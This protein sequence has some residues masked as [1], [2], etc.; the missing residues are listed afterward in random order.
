[1]VHKLLL[2]R[3]GFPLSDGNTK[4][5]DL[6]SFEKYK[7]CN[8]NGE[9]DVHYFHSTL[10]C[11][12]K[13][14]RWK[15]IFTSRRISFKVSPSKIWS[16]TPKSNGPDP[17]LDSKSPQG[18]EY[19]YRIKPY[20]FCSG[21]L[22]AVLEARKEKSQNQ[23]KHKHNKLLWTFMLYKL[24]HDYEFSWK[25]NNKLETFCSKILFGIKINLHIR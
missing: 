4:Y 9:L 23:F 19:T 1:M 16:H 13:R 20:L 8:T 12:E 14:R 24:A 22:I 5:F 21:I 18:Q 7:S 10:F 25:V 15:T 17:K 3:S 11:K 6:P 2:S